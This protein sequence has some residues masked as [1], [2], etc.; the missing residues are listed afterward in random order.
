M[1]VCLWHLRVC[2]SHLRV[3]LFF[4]WYRA[5]VSAYWH[6]ACVSACLSS[7]CEASAVPVPDLLCG[8]LSVCSPLRQGPVR[9]T[10]R[11]VY[12]VCARSNKCLCLTYCVCACLCGRVLSEL[13][14]GLSAEAS[15]SEGAI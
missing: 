7:L 11:P 3:C 1:P 15:D 13:P 12:P 6:L 14:H 5:G 10:T 4:V 9:A 2:L 8:C